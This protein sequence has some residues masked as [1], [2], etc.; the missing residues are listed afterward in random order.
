MNDPIGQTVAGY[1]I[2][3]PIG[4]DAYGITYQAA[5]SGAPVAIKILREDLRANLALSTAIARGWESARV[6]MHANLLTI[7][8]TGID[9]QFGVYCLHELVAGKSLRDLILT[10]SRIAW[11]DCF[12]F[13]EQLFSGLSALHAANICHGN[14]W[15]STILI[16]QDQDLKLGDAGG[17][18]SLN[19]PMTEI[20]SGPVLG[21]LAPECIQG[22]APYKGS[23]IY[24]SGACL[25][26]ILAGQDPNSGENAGTIAR[27]PTPISALRDDLPA[28]AQEF[29]AR[30]M[31]VDPVRRYAS[32]D[33]VLSD[34]LRLKSGESLLP[35][36]GGN[37]LE[38]QVVSAPARRPTTVKLGSQ[39][40]STAA[41]TQSATPQTNALNGPRPDS[42]IHTRVF[43]RLDTHVKSTIPKSDSEK[44]GDDLYRKGQLPLALTCWREA[45]IEMPH[46]ALKVKIEMAEKDLQ[47]EAYRAA[48]EE[49][50]LRVNSGDYRGAMSRAREAMPWANDAKQSQDARNLIQ[51]A[52]NGE[53]EEAKRTKIKVIIAGVVFFIMA[54]TFIWVYESYKGT[55]EEEVGSTPV[56][57][58]ARAPVVQSPAKFAIAT[59]GASIVRP[60]Q[61]T[62]AIASGGCL[63]E[64]HGM[65]SGTSE[66]AVIMRV[67]KC[68]QGTKLAD[69]QIELRTKSD[70]KNPTRIEEAELVFFIDGAYQCS[71]LGF[72]Y[73][74]SNDKIGIRY[75]Y[76]LNGPAESLY[77]V[78]F[79]GY[80]ATFTYELRAQM[81]VIMQS[82]TFEK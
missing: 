80:E 61:W 71:E 49:A 81:R 28:E 35:L 72:R 19:C 47:K 16:T 41:Q 79:D 14:I 70:L 4:K 42:G 9:P 50:Q 60:A 1:P 34:L 17:L 68:G 69:K 32:V 23:D 82:W 64:L 77:M 18:T 2:Q 6:V 59:S 51:V 55:N 66:T 52:Q 63:V 76:L 45:Y 53:T 39:S 30:M 22:H 78:D 29:I 74:M 62:I 44:R 33:D 75:T 37:P 57:P 73:A 31:A 58:V 40:Q 27:Q 5:T 43:G 10:G 3:K 20:L 24:S 15:P 36:K 21:Y 48:M 13:A 54:A 8:S 46:T 7:F 25:Y 65:Q 11:R 56:A 26:F 12:I 38:Q 67:F